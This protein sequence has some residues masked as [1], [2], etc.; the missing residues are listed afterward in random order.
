MEGFRKASVLLVAASL[1]GG[2]VAIPALAVG[3]D[4]GA[5]TVA[6]KKKKC[7]KSKNSS[8][9]TAKKRCKK[10]TAAP[11]ATTPPA[12]TPPATYQL[13]YSAALAAITDEIRSIANQHLAITGK[14][15]WYSVDANSCHW[16]TNNSAQIYLECAAY[17]TIY[18][19]IHCQATGF[20]YSY[21]KYFIVARLLN[22]S[23]PSVTINS[24]DI[25]AADICYA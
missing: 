14:P 12:T 2:V 21:R 25:N 13:T 9:S 20:T 8:A 23:S 7:K 6:K 3:H 1:F 19:P 18:D 22:P 16:G 5:A 11:P 17:L 24:V 10:S 4:P 15:T